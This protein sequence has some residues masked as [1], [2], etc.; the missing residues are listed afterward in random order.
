MKKLILIV[1]ATILMVGCQENGISVKTTD[2][3]NNY[4]VV[5]LFEIDGIS[6]YRFKD[7]SNYVYFTN[8]NGKVKT[9]G[10]R[11]FYNPGTK[12]GMVDNVTIETICN[13]DRGEN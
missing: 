12:T 9:I 7:G 3:E 13:K 5:K 4:K 2:L 8:S 6:I 10:K 1:L 11:Y